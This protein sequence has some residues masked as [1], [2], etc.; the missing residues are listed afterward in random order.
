MYLKFQ[1]NYTSKENKIPKLGEFK[2]N[3]TADSVR[4]RKF[5]SKPEQKKRRAERNGS[6]AIVAKKVG[7]AKIKGK[8]I[9]HADHNT[10]NHSAKN[11]SVMSAKSNRSKN[12]YDK[13][14]KVK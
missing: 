4:Q 2:K 1:Q 3:A 14:K 6:R 10:A 8:D 7:K 9:D 12:Q 13:R 5:N 11:L